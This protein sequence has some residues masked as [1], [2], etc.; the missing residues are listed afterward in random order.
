MSG[1]VIVGAGPAGV[2]TA[3]LLVRDGIEV[4]R[5]SAPPTSRAPF[6]ATA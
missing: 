2:A 1:V 5:P 3:H 6:A 4:A